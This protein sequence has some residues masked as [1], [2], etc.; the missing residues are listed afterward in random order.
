MPFQK[1]QSGNPAGRPK[2]GETIT[3]ILR[4]RLEL[5]DID[6]DDGRKITRAE[7]LVD[8]VMS[9]AIEDGDVASIRYI[10]DRIDG[11]PRQSV[12]MTGAD[13]AKLMPEKIIIEIVDPK[14][15]KK[16]IST[17]DTL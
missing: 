3:D 14:K 9:L 10:F 6:T 11:S 16:G 13:G 17:N 12:E 4:G 5:K 8:K 2:K 1:G 7:A 15:P